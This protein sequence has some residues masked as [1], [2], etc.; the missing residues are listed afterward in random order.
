MIAGCQRVKGRASGFTLI[1]TLIAVALF[2]ILMVITIGSLTVLIDSNRKARSEK[3]VIN[4]VNAA[5]E[6]MSRSIRDGSGYV[7]TPNPNCTGANGQIRFVAKDGSTIVYRVANNTIERSVNGGTSFTPI[8][9]PE[10]RVNNLSFEA[11]GISGEV[12]KFQITVKATT[13]GENATAADLNLQTTVS[14]RSTFSAPFTKYAPKCGNAKCEWGE[15]GGSCAAD[16]V[17]V[18]GG[19]SVCGNNICEW[20]ESGSCADCH[21]QIS[22]SILG[23]DV[24]LVVDYSSSLTAADKT[25]VNKS[26]NYLVNQA[27]A[28]NSQTKI[29]IIKYIGPAWLLTH[30][31]GTKAS[32]IDRISNH[33]APSGGG[34]NTATAL[35]AALLEFQGK[36][37]IDETMMNGPE[38]VNMP[39][40]SIADVRN[41]SPATNRSDATYPNHV[42]LITDGAANSYLAAGATTIRKN[43]TT[44][45]SVTITKDQWVS[46]ICPPKPDGSLYIWRDDPE[47]DPGTCW[48]GTLKSMESMQ[49]EANSLKSLATLH[50]ISVGIADSTCVSPG[51]TVWLRDRIASSPGN[52]HAL[53]NYNE[54]LLNSVI[55]DIMEGSEEFT[56]IV[57]NCSGCATGGTCDAKCVKPVSS[58]TTLSVDCT[59]CGLG[60]AC[61]TG[62]TVPPVLS[63][64]SKEAEVDDF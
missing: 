48:V 15:S 60:G 8:T 24:M 54:S 51:C 3:S 35:R 63:T 18:T 25:V 49:R 57:T 47:P 42:I 31:T 29:G 36:E 50:V 17:V 7:C 40:G 44:A 19:N 20:G 61:P 32:L 41:F 16:C 43:P 33:S 34:T 38:S 58:T 39:T 62:C 9:S 26:A 53:P 52:Y 55:D 56:E 64:T 13:I 11:V 6:I 4:N 28:R 45:S 2:S 30:M 10:V 23:G 5:V 22:S 21:E 37:E 14:Q 27:L 59:Q 12:P 46:G 1:E